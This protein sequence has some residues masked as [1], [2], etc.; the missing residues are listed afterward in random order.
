M[1]INN[2]NQIAR[3]DN[4]T[5]CVIF[6]FEKY[7]AN[8]FINIIDVQFAVLFV[9]LFFGITIREMGRKVNDVAITM[10]GIM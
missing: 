2:G 7:N 1:Q 8:F 4:F 5:S 6:V 9:K 10:I 3:P